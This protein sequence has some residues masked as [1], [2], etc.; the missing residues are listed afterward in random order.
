MPD[1][2]EPV[3]KWN[4]FYQRAGVVEAATLACQYSDQTE[5][6]S[7]LMII[8]YDWMGRLLYHH[9]LDQAVGVRLLPRAL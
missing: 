5:S 3:W 6:M 2:D 7:N 8:V 1:R 4:A 9:H